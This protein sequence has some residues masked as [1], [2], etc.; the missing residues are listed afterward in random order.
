[1]KVGGVSNNSLKNLIL[2]SIE[3]MMVIRKNKLPIFRAI[4]GKN[5][6]KIPQFLIKK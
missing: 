4:V 3:D 5:I 1:M 2:K 6:S